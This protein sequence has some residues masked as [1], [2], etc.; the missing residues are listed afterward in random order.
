MGR[1]DGHVI[2]KR[3]SECPKMT[4]GFS[5][6]G[7]PGARGDCPGRRVALAALLRH[8]GVGSLLFF[9]VAVR[10]RT[11]ERQLLRYLKDPQRVVTRPV[12]DA[13][14]RQRLYPA[15]SGSHWKHPTPMQSR[16]DIG[17]CVM[18]RGPGRPSIW[19]SVFESHGALG[20]DWN[21]THRQNCKIE[22][23]ADGKSELRL[24]LDFAN[25]TLLRDVRHSG[26]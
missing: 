16:R 7:E 14:V 5:S 17:G 2:T 9:E 26:Y 15:I 21:F 23:G 6:P 18:S 8:A 20:Q 3:N 11:F 22:T 24:V 19:V 13:N 10:L 25:S 1:T 4:I 12:G